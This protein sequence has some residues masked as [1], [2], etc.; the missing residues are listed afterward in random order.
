MSSDDK[1]SKYVGSAVISVRIH[2]N[3]LHRLNSISQYKEENRGKCRNAI[4][5]RAIKRLLDEV[6][7][8]GG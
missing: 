3:L 8:D 7:E 4:I 5:N 1:E 6:E 2:Q